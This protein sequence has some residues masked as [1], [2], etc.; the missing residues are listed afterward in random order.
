M[1][2]SNKID[3]ARL[4]LSSGEGRRVDLELDPG[5]LTYGG[6]TYAT[7][8]ADPGQ[9]EV[10]RMSSGYAFR[11]RRAVPGLRRIAQRRRARRPRPRERARPAL[12]EA[13]RA[14]PRLAPRLGGPKVDVALPPDRHPPQHGERAGVRVAVNGRG[15]CTRLPGGRRRS[16]PSPG[17]PRGRAYWG[18]R[19]RP[20]GYHARSH[21][22][23]EE[24]N[25]AD[26]ARQAPRHPSRRQAASE[27]VPTLPQPAPPTPRVS[28][29]R[30]LRRA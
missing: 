8:H 1:P 4:S 5:T 19:P 24:E 10:S 22:G 15:P 11:L 16:S 3:L 25:L 13:A 30:D 29:L 2:A 18:P 21:G 27:R 28:R 23:P 14:E 7:S 20:A 26:A 9:V 12:G 6:Q 17:P